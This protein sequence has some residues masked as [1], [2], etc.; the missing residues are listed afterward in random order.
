VG[1]TLNNVL[2]L[3]VSLSVKNVYYSLVS[4]YL[5]DFY[6]GDVHNGGYTL[7]N[8]MTV[9]GAGV[10]A[11]I[12]AIYRPVN[13]LRIGLAWHTPTW[14]ALSETYGAEMEEDIKYYLPPMWIM[15]REASARLFSR[16]IT[17]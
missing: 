10:G 14:Y 5:E 16:M 12:G 9:K 1:T 15:R 2:N 7:N 4:H 6:D 13:S 17:I 3:G 8:E 11:K